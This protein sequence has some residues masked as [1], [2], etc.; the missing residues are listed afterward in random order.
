V[1]NK[2]TH[3]NDPRKLAFAM[4]EATKI[5]IEKTKGKVLH[6]KVAK[7]KFFMFLCKNFIQKLTEWQQK[8]FY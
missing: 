8:N 6:N 4:L 2:D 5:C 7:N 3:L 1:E